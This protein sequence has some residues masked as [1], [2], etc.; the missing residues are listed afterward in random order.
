MLEASSYKSDKVFNKFRKRVA[1]EPE[2]I[3]RYDLGGEPLWVS[4]DNTP[5]KKDIPPC[6][7]CKGKRVFEFQVMPQLLNY[8]GKDSVEGSVDWGTIA[9]YTCEANCN[10]DDQV[11]FEFVWK[12]DYKPDEIDK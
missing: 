10:P 5:E 4:P 2:Q 11:E 6:P 8:L 1:Y 7:R 3:L 12:Q 9:V